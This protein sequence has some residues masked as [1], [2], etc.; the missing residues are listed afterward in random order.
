[1]VQIIPPPAEKIAP[2]FTLEL[3]NIRLTAAQF[4]RICRDNRDLRLELAS[5]G[6]LIIMPPTGSRMGQRNA[7]LTRQLAT[8]AQKDGTGVA[9]DSSTGFTL[10]NGA[11]LSP[12]ASWVRRE[13]WD[14][15]SE[16]EQEGFAP[17]CPDFVIEL[18][19]HSNTLKSL[20]DKMQEYMEN[21]AQMAWLI[22]PV[23]RRIYFY[24]TGEKVETLIDPA[25]VSADPILRGFVLQLA[26]LW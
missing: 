10:P 22:D 4:Q 14:A 3:R 5:N 24:R 12:D 23:E 8:W 18:R 16:E 2:F 26:E 25:T 21:R 19:S 1:M 15:V 9:F 7:N 17:L 13:R 11:I 6:D 20:Q